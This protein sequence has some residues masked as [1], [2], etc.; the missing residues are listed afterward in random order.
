MQYALQSAII[1]ILNEVNVKVNIMAVWITLQL[2]CFM[3]IIWFACIHIQ[4][5]K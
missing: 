3:N 2:S 5:Y 4:K 1:L